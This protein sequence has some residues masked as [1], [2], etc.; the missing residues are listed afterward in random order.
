MSTF[1][2]EREVESYLVSALEKL[3][4]SCLKFDPSNRVGMPD[5]VVLL[6]DSKVIWVELKTDN[7]R[8][9]SIQKLRHMELKRMGQEVKVIWNRVD[10]DKF[11]EELSERINPHT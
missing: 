9:S 10:V 7:G 4:L 8:L 2:R 3:N 5:R 6:P 1:V 11:T